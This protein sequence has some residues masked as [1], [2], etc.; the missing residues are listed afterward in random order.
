MEQRV[1]TWQGNTI[2][3]AEWFG[4]EAQRLLNGCGMNPPWAVIDALFIQCLPIPEA[5][6]ATGA[7][8]AALQEYQAAVVRE[9]LRETEEA[10]REL[11][12]ST[13]A[14]IALPA[15]DGGPQPHGV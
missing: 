4:R 6:R 7:D 3:R 14:V 10:K 15:S 9:A 11:N 1:Y 8:V 12:S 2:T 5:S 13:V